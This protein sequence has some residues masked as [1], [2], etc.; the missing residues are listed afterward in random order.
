MNDRNT[1][2]GGREPARHRRVLRRI[3]EMVLA[4]SL[5]IGAAAL[6]V[7][8]GYLAGR[9]DTPGLV[10]DAA[11]RP[12][13]SPASAV[14]PPP[15]LPPVDV[16]PAPT[17]RTSSPPEPGAS[18]PVAEAKERAERRKPRPMSTPAPVTISIPDMDIAQNV[19]ELGVKGSVLQ[20]PK[21]Y[22]D[23]GWWRDGP[24][25]GSAGA[26]AV[27]G[28]VDSPDGPAV[29]YQLAGLREGAEI[30]VLRKDGSTAVFAIDRVERYSRNAFPS[31]Q[32]YRVGGRSALHLITCGG[33]YDRE[34]GQYEDNVV[35][36]AYLMDIRDANP[37]DEQKETDS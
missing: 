7:S 20:T 8:A 13:S 3:G 21:D 1:V 17:E 37:A 14:R 9:L 12:A 23:I 26:A 34:A 33:D 36:Y 10:A 35:A 6:L 15:P 19:V 22:G 2:T 29:F 24:T 25:P 11:E 18:G 16:L 31:E 32:V 27:V 4:P 28:H 5:F 30:S